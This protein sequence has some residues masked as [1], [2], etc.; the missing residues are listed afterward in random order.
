[1]KIVWYSDE[2][3]VIHAKADIS[4]GE[5]ILYV[6]EN[7]LITPS[8]YGSIDICQRVSANPEFNSGSQIETSNLLIVLWIL[9]YNEH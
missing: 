5:D 4:S 6:P 3:R 7:I 2:N 9:T 8:V 1:M